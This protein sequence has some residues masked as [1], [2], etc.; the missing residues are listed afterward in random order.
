MIFIRENRNIYKIHVKYN[1]ILV[2]KTIMAIEKLTFNVR[3]SV[4]SW[5]KLRW[6][7]LKT[8]SKSYSELILLL[9]KNLPTSSSKQ[10]ELVLYYLNFRKDLTKKFKTIMINKN[11]RKSLEK[12]KLLSNVSSF[13]LS[14]AIYFLIFVNSL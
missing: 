6:A 10:K 7:K 14:D 1:Y 8:A 11:A 13:T 12:I 9:E 4:E 3:I 2:W 5:Q